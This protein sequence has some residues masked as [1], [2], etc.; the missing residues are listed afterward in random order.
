MNARLAVTPATLTVAATAASREYGAADP[1]FA[2][3]VTGFKNGETLASATSGAFVF[4]TAATATS[5][6]GQYRVDV[7]GLTAA[8]GN[9]V[10]T[11]DV[12]NT[13]ALTVTPATLTVTAGNAAKTY[14][15]QAFVG[16]STLSY[17]GFRN[18]ESVA[19]LGGSVSFAGTSQGAINAGSYAITPS[20]L[21]AANYTVNFVSGTLTVNKAALTL[22]GNDA[23]REYGAADPAFSSTLTGFVNGETAVTAGVIGSAG[24]VSS[25]LA[26][27]PVGTY[28]YTPTAGTYAAAN[29]A[30]TQ[31]V[32]GRVTVTPATLSIVAQAA[33][34]T[35]GAAEPTFVGSITGLRNGDALSAAVAGT[36]AFTTDATLT[37]NVGTYALTGSGLSPVGANYVLAQAAGNATA[38]SVTPASL[39]VNVASATKTYDGNVYTGGAGV[40]YA[41]FL[42]GDTST[43]L[44]GSPTYAGN[45]QGARHAGSYVL[46]AGGQTA[47][48]YSLSYVPGTLTVSAKTITATLTA[49]DKVYDG[50]TAATGSLTLVGLVG[51]ETLG[52][53]FTATFNSKDV[54][55]ANLVTASSVQ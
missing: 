3:T 29:Y 39:T 17:A 43:V 51:S 37:S 24:G 14:D 30:F 32:D 44:A 48:N 9:Y 10:F 28:A 13:T 16:G 7:S 54:S 45:S 4:A 41:G 20:G 47:A 35:Y 31:F 6:V 26:A 18:N 15:G 38:L 21:S 22:T 19:V 1:A 12:A 2:A 11:Q 8:S 34:R 46:T 50:M 25:A 49:N 33:T 23:T 27:S 40:S 53:A 36:L 52:K 42:N 55:T 5:G